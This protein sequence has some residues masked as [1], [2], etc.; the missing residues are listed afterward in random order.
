M[1]SILIS[2]SFLTAILVTFSAH[3]HDAKFHKGKPV[4]GTVT[5]VSPDGFDLQTNDGALH[6][7]CGKD[8]IIEKDNSRA[9]KED[10]KKD[11]HVSVIGTKLETGEL[12]AREIVTTHSDSKHE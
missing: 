4:H 1:K 12:V 11:M 3:A 2:L 6:V 10:I 5:T 9:S 7:V 8:A